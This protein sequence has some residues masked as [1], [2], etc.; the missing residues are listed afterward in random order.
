MEPLFGHTAHGAERGQ[1]TILFYVPCTLPPATLLGTLR[2]NSDPQERFPI[3]N[4]D[5]TPSFH[6][7]FVPKE[8][9]TH[10]LSAALMITVSAR[11]HPEESRTL[12]FHRLP[13]T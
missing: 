9:S 12:H 7:V 6:S 11:E 4:K 2:I 13:G 1:P 10:N 3:F 8:V 5:P